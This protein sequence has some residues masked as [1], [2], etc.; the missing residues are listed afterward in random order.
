MLNYLRS[1]WY[2]TVRRKYLYLFVGVVVLIAAAYFALI[3]FN[4]IAF[5]IEEILPFLV[6]LLPNTG[7]YAILLV[8]DA[9]FSDEHKH[10]TMKNT[11]SFGVPRTRVY[12]GKLLN[13]LLFCVLSL[14]ALVALIIGSGLLLGGVGDWQDFEEGM[15]FLGKTLLASFPLWLCGVA[16][17]NAL[18][19]NIRSSV[20]WVFAYIGVFNG[21]NLL[22]RA[23]SGVIPVCR[24]I[25][26]YLPS[27]LLSQLG[28]GALLEGAG[29]SLMGLCWIVGLTAA[30][31]FI[32]A[33]LAV[34]CRTEVK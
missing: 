7:L 11:I 4:Q 24:T 23:L 26:E 14:A 32:A 34:F 31:I 18:S 12:F 6:L 33:G 5:G 9:A 22:L 15:Q 27:Y 19:C 1:E 28:E 29:N 8:H 17:A 16:A 2:R 20:G 10:G 3:R 21:F 30:A 13:S 25:R